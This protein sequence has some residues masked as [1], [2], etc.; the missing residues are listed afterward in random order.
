[1]CIDKKTKITTHGELV[2]ELAVNPR[3]AAFMINVYIEEKENERLLTLAATIVAIL[4]AS[5]SLF[6]TTNT[7]NDPNDNIHNTITLG[8]K[9][10]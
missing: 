8:F 9:R 2:A 1:M 3:L 4:S 5:A 10:L 7:T 6:S